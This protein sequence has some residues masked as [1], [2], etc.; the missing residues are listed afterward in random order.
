LKKFI[1]GVTIAL[2]PVSLWAQNFIVG[3][4]ITSDSQKPLSGANI[5]LKNT[6]FTITSAVNGEFRIAVLKPGKY[7]LQVSYVGY[8]TQIQTV[9]SGN[10]PNIIILKNNQFLA[11][12]VMVT[13]TR[14]S[15]NAATTLKNLSKAEIEINNFGQDIPFLLN[16]TPSVVVSS[17]AGA[18]IGYTGIR[19][20]GSDA[21]RIN[22]TVNGIPINDTE[23]QGMFWVNMPDFASSI[24]NIQIQR[25]VGT[26]TNG[27]AAFGASLNIQTN[28]RQDTAYTEVNT[29]AGSFRSLR[30]TLKL[31]TGL[32][33][34]KFSF[35]GRLSRIVS[36]GYIDRGSSDLKSYFVTGAYYGKN[37]LL[38]INAFSGKEKTYQAW[39]GVPQDSLATNRRY[40]SFNYDNQTDNYQQS[41]YQML[42]SKAI[43]P[44]I[45]FNGALHYTK[46]AGYYEEFKDKE[47][48]ADYNLTPITV[49]NALIDS[50]DLIR[51]KWLDNDFYGL[52]YSFIYTPNNQFNFT[53]GGGY[54]QYDGDHFTEVIWV[55]YAA[56]SKIRHR[57]NENNGFKTDFNVF[58][59]AQYQI[60]D[61]SLFADM[62]Y[63]KITYDFIGFNNFGQNVKQY[64]ALHFFNPKLGFTYTIDMQSNLYASFSVG[65][66]EANRDE[67]TQSTPASRPKHEN[68]QN[69]EAGYRFKKQGISGGINLYSMQYRN[70]L[71]LTGQINDVGEYIRNNVAKSYR[72]GIELD[73]AI[74]ILPSLSWMLNA[75]ASQ[76]K[77]KN[78]NEFIDDYDNGGQL[79]N[80]YPKTD[81]AFS[82]NFVG[83]ST[84]SFKPTKNAEIALL[85]KYVSSQ[86]LDNTSNNSRKINA[87]FVNDV[88]L[89][90]NIKTKAIKN[91]GL[92]LQVNNIFNKLYAS[93]G[94]TF[95]YLSGGLVNENFYYPQATTNFMASVNLKF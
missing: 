57:L 74:P 85:S 33:N 29:S 4:V 30:N 45:A 20:R 59:K 14:A 86:F 8:Q 46:G 81:I 60:N 76:N 3:K 89:H 38:R 51:R 43:S 15:E 70:Q 2:L 40:N 23:S 53:L 25:G 12:E 93:N 39:N 28:T 56:D 1:V 48:F 32:I 65:N 41:H 9:E 69:I 73:I 64:D 58:A 78:F 62:Q 80:T 94:Y 67:Y 83:G 37:S 66:K 88:R 18:G 87:F 91:I 54:N 24:D 34:G 84:L 7:V 5:I 82:P 19:I 31:G 72:N 13:A 77:I 26:S 17:D 50:T 16:Q 55:Q 11:D 6:N 35:D 22:V 71:V 10:N 47:P 61:L 42:Y 95:S 44:K 90:Y 52:T 75:A 49:G 68:L 27:A 79:L 36:D 92:G 21:T 63:R